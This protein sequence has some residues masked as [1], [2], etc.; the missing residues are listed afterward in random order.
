MPEIQERAR[1]LILRLVYFG[2]PG[3]GKAAN[4]QCIHELLRDDSRSRIRSVSTGAERS[5]HFDTTLPAEAGGIGAVAP[6]EE[7]WRV[8]LA[9]SGCSSPLLKESK[10]AILASADAIAFVAHGSRSKREE[11]HEA[12]RELEALLRTRRGRV[13]QLVLQVNRADMNGAQADEEVEREWAHRSC[14][15]FTASPATGEG[16]RETFTCL[17]RLAYEEANRD[18]DLVSETGLTLPGVTAAALQ[19]MRQTE[20]RV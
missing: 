8:T 20:M 18:L 7:P 6:G 17:L 4:L 15:I 13:P 12:M 2:P 19:A 14:P 3:S 10:A 9:V 5:L 16:V 1:R 11:N